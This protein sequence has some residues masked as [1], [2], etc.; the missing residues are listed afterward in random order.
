MFSAVDFVSDFE[1]DWLMQTALWLD[2]Q[3]AFYIG[4]SAG[5]GKRIADRK[6]WRPRKNSK[7]RRPGNMKRN[8]SKSQQ[9][10]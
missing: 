4:K 1:F 10:V 7:T 5:M 6:T 9:H 8:R 3:I 2:N